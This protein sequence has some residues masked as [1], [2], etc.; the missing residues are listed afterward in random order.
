MERGP[1]TDRPSMTETVWN[2]V[3]G[4]WLFRDSILVL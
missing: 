3:L 1:M 2:L 4:Y